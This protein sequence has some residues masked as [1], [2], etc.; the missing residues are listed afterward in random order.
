MTRI[1]THTTV[2]NL[3]SKGTVKELAEQMVKEFA[4]RD[5]FKELVNK[6]D[7]H[8]ELE[9]LKYEITNLKSD[10]KDI[11]HDI[12]ELKVQMAE[13]KSSNKFVLTILM[14][15]ALAIYIPLLKTTFFI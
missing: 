11:K 14:A 8:N 4:L 12:S 6:Q 3:I 15:I 2:E 10:V 7:L 5:E 1:D 9:P 13:L